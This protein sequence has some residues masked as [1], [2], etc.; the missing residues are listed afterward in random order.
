[1]ETILNLFPG[2]YVRDYK[3]GKEIRT[4][5]L[6]IALEIARKAIDK[7]KLEVEIFDINTRL[8]SFSIR[9]K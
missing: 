3:N 9:Q 7:K 2:A 6:D 8:K 1:M 4:R 5:N